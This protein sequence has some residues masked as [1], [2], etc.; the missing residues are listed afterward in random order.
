MVKPDHLTGSKIC[1]NP[2]L[3]QKKNKNTETEPKL[4]LG[5]HRQGRRLKTGEKGENSGK[6]RENS[7]TRGN[8]ILW[9]LAHP[10]KFRQFYKNSIFGRFNEHTPPIKVV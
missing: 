10:I 8:I 3:W 1:T 2:F 4:R 6:L 9:L 5:Y 7:V